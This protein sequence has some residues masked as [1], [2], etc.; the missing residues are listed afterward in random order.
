MMRLPAMSDRDRRTV[1]IAA[2]AIAVYLLLFGGFKA[3]SYCEQKRTDYRQLQATA[4]ELRNRAIAYQ[5]KAI[6]LEK[7]MDDLHLDPARLA[8]EKT[9]SGASEAIQKA[10][11]ARG[12]GIGS[13][14]ETAAHGSS[15]SLAT[16]Q[17][18]GA[19]PPAAALAFLAGLNTI[20]FPV[21][22]DSVQFASMGAPGVMKMNLT[23]TILD[24]SKQTGAREVPHA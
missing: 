11:M 4:K 1:R 13:I 9:M 15:Q 16:V 5:Q 23:L 14:R 7:L 6:L 2:L 19:G 24:F 17:L 10:A 12:F 3:W 21:V 20:G 8:R 22:V 18:E